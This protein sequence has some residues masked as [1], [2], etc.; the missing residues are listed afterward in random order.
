V[1]LC[2]F[3]G[4]RDCGLTVPSAPIRLR[5]SYTQ[6]DEALTQ[7]ICKLLQ[8]AYSFRRREVRVQMAYRWLAVSFQLAPAS[9]S[10]LYELAV[11]VSPCRTLTVATVS[12]S[13]SEL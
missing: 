9:V 1:L 12:T 4:G 11:S 7:Q 3:R 8:L 6:N 5:V 13:V 10:R 2:E